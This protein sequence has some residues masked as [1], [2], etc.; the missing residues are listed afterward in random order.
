[1][2]TWTGSAITP[3]PVVTVGGNILTAT[4]DYLVNYTDNTHIG[5]ATVTVTGTGAYEGTLSKTFQIQH[6]D[7][8]YNSTDGFYE[9]GNE[10]ALRAL[11][12]YVNSGGATS[13]K[14]F[15][16]TSDITLTS[17]F[18]PIGYSSERNFKGTYDGGNYTISGLTVSGNVGFAALFGYMVGATVRNVILISPS[19][20]GS[21]GGSRV[22]ALVGYMNTGNN[23]SAIENCRVVNPTLSATGGGTNYVGVFI[24]EWGSHCSIS[25][26]YFYDSNTEHNYAAFENGNNVP[27]YST[28]SNTERV[29]KITAADCTATATKTV[30]IDG[31]DYYKNGTAVTISNPADAPTGYH[32]DGYTVNGTAINGDSYTINSAD[33][34]ISTAFPA[35]TYT[36]AFDK[37]NADA[38]G[39]MD[40]QNFTYDEADKALTANAFER[41]GY[42]F[43]GWNTEAN[44]SGTAYADKAEVQNLTAEDGA[45]VTLYAQW[46]I[47]KYTVTWKN[48]DNT[49]L[50]KEEN[51]PYGT[52]P[53]YDGETPTKAADA[54]YTY[55]FKEW[56]PAIAYVTDDAVYT[57]TY[58]KTV[59]KY[60]VTLPDNM[61]ITNGVTLTDGKADYGTEIKF[62]V[63]DG[64]TASNVKANGTDLT[65]T[66]GVYT[67]T[68][69][70]DTEIT[71]MVE[72]IT[73]EIYVTPKA[74][75]GSA[76]AANITGTGSYDHGTYAEL[77]ALPA[78]GY[79]F[80]GWFASTVEAPYNK[81]DALATANDFS[82]LVNSGAS[83]V[84][85]YEALASVQVTINAP[86]FTVNGSAHTSQL[87]ENYK[88]GTKL[89]IAA[90]GDNFAYWENS[91][92]MVLSRSA[93]YTYTVTGAE[94]ITAVFDTPAGDEIA[95]L[96]FESAYGQVMARVQL[97]EEQATGYTVPSVPFRNGYNSVGWDL[98]ADGEYN[99]DD[100]IANAVAKALTLTNNLLTIRPIYTEKTNTFAI[101]VTGGTITS[102]K[103]PIDGKYLQNSKITV[104]A[105]EPESGQ[106]FSHWTDGTSI[107][108]YNTSYQFFADR[109]LALTAVFVTEETPVEAV[110]TT[111][112]IE[113]YKD[114]ENGKLTF[115]SMSTV[116]EGCA[117]VKAGIIATADST[118]GT[119]G[120][121]FNDKTATHVR[122]NPWNGE[123]YRFTWNKLAS[124]GD[125]W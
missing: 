12:T 94:T 29:Y 96:V 91:Y 24:G 44:G 117:I 84:A 11:S 106:K 108:G 52:T 27:T 118:V 3:A 79:N 65:A 105:D 28:V 85:V 23:G 115:V 71:A 58:D 7:M 87:K 100:K 45:T 73:Y 9:I 125:T 8:P 119:S 61:E 51:V 40:I 43:K 72:I 81:A 82:L 2:Q 56:D 123:G 69:E 76:V 62:K 13:G 78:E 48:E 116:P 32:F 20:S 92:G 1:M 60:A 33:A 93:N 26:C 6:A 86:S 39:T 42:T 102:D 80:V 19:A 67:V 25:N 103:A 120:D 95:T 113:M 47:N 49:E 121:G 99:E 98:N 5:T 77:K 37:N 38:T 18:S 83:Y 17:A 41:T 70:E 55:T 4:T 46:E 64:Y 59:N 114:T 63:K 124:T 31:T 101:T 36:V 15:K 34:N 111:E 53:S 110:G 89:T 30:T 122:G 112:I 88:L 75:D 14:T 21:H 35:N 16:Q 104:T 66:D 109:D 107:L 22:S 57:A 50:E 74:V 10:T 68:V 97:T 54:Q 90:S